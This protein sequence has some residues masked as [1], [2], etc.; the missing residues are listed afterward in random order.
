MIFLMRNCLK[1]AQQ[2]Q[3]RIIQLCGSPLNI[4]NNVSMG[5]PLI[6]DAEKHALQPFYSLNLNISSTQQNPTDQDGARERNEVEQSWSRGRSSPEKG[7]FR[8]WNGATIISS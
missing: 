4:I 3:N 2:C 7:Y 8:T 6:P 1:Y 5:N